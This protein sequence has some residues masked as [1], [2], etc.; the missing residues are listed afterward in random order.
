MR[1]AV[2]E[3]I[4]IAFEEG[5][6][7]EV[8]N[9]L[10]PNEYTKLC[11]E[12]LSECRKILDEIPEEVLA[13]SE[14]FCVILATWC[15]D[16]NEIANGNK[17]YT[18]IVLM[19]DS[20]KENSP[21][22]NYLRYIAALLNVRAPHKNNAQ[23]MQSL[24]ILYDEF[25]RTSAKARDILPTNGNPSVLRGAKDLSDLA[26]NYRAV[27]GILKPVLTAMSA[28]EGVSVFGAAVAEILYE[29]NKLRA[30]LEEAKNAQETTS[31]EILFAAIAQYVRT[32]R[33]DTACVGATTLLSQYD[34]KIMQSGNHN[35]IKNYGALKVR[36]AMET[37][38]T[39]TVSA[40]AEE[41]KS[42][43]NS[44]NLVELYTVITLAK[45]YIALEQY[46]DA[47]SLLQTVINSIENLHRPL[48]MAECLVSC[49]VAHSLMGAS[50]L[51]IEK[52]DRAIAITRKYEYVRVYADAGN[53]ILPIL[54]E[55]V[56][57]KAGDKYLKAICDASYRFSV[58]YPT[59]FVKG[60]VAPEEAPQIP[61]AV[62]EP[63]ETV[64]QPDV[65]EETQVET[66]EEVV[67]EAV[68]PEQTEET[69]ETVT[70]ETGE[71][72]TEQEINVLNLLNDG[73][74]NNDIAGALSVKANVV[75]NIIKD[76]FTKM[77]VKNRAEA[78]SVAKEKGYIE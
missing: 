16:N 21:E 52:L 37:G 39:A 5:N 4:K 75:K 46:A 22:K 77:G 73:K 9:I 56:Q 38:D 8:A 58:M 36:F 28:D 29:K 78:I 66:T 15:W 10:F 53:A 34:E 6:Y 44:R 65:I 1:V 48:D 14:K 3:R 26:M 17:W 60:G 76:I 27:Y 62:E 40:W 70:E 47:V 11:V 49:A 61:D 43:A 35:I 31:D 20:A 67:A 7:D 23:L 74:S 19:R 42:L 30:A 72:L 71:L 2:Y 69:V 57:N 13:G 68:A 63:E 59:L 45:A 41:N 32:S 24:A 50:E 51:A 18:N 25:L 12:E 64:A 54:S 55:Y 33:L